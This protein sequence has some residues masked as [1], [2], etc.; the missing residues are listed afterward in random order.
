MTTK[1]ETLLQSHL[2]KD[3]PALR[4]G[5]T[6]KVYQKIKEADKERI[7][8]FEGLVIARKHGQEI[9]STITVRKIISGVGVEKI[10]PLHSP[11]IDKIEIIKKVKVRRAKLYYLR[12]GKGK[13]TRL[14]RKGTSESAAEQ[15]TPEETLSET[16]Q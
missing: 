16:S 2:K 14:K 3:L 10:F 9:G 13:K 15:R 6:V 4:S 12:K 5:D 11:L 7:Q 8:I 1:I